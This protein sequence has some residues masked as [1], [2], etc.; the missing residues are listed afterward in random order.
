MDQFQRARWQGVRGQEAS[1]YLVAYKL[2]EQKRTR[3][4]E[5]AARQHFGEQKTWR[6]LLDNCIISRSDSMASAGEGLRELSHGAQAVGRRACIETCI[7]MARPQS[8]DLLT[9]RDSGIMYDC[10]VVD[11]SGAGITAAENDVK[12]NVAAGIDLFVQRVTSEIRLIDS[13]NY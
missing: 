3:V 7:L 11:C 1:A 10:S 6:R 5:A 12:D 2:S 9:E 4:F 13:E 8:S